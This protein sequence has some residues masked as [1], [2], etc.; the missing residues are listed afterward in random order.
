MVEL[1]GCRLLRGWGGE[2]WD[3]GIT[4]RVMVGW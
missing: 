4:S 3:G 1:W 2:I